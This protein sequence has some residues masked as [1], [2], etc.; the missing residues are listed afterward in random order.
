[1]GDGEPG[2]GRWRVLFLTQVFPRHEGD[3]IGAFLLHLG[4]RLAAQKVEL[5][6]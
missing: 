1:M 3:L 5:S 2:G 4:Q 6:P